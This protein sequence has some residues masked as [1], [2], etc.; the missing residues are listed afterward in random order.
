MAGVE[1]LTFDSNIR[2]AYFKFVTKVCPGETFDISQEIC[3]GDVSE[4]RQLS[5]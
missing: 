4:I 2:T 3:T 1:I 5:V